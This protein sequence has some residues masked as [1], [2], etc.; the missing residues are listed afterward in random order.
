MM[1]AGTAAA[2]NVFGGMTEER[3]PEQEQK[4]KTD[5]NDEALYSLISEVSVDKFDCFENERIFVNVFL[6]LKLKMLEHD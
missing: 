4:T 2:L 1:I 5:A 3:Q 6:V